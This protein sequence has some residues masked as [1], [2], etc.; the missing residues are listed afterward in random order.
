M[1]CNLLKIYRGEKIKCR[2]GLEQ[3]QIFLTLPTQHQLGLYTQ[4]TASIVC[5][6]LKWSHIKGLCLCRV[7]SLV[8]C[9]AQQGDSYL[10]QLLTA[11]PSPNKHITSTTGGRG[12]QHSCQPPLFFY[13]AAVPA[14]S[15]VLRGIPS[16]N[17][18]S[19]GGVGPGLRPVSGPVLS[20]GCVRAGEDWLARL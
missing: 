13:P 6:D 15:T 3:K 5:V 4:L 8:L 19:V 11:A 10:S 12:Q 20:A 16:M 14:K 9:P 1:F 7:D 17:R 2:V 18:C